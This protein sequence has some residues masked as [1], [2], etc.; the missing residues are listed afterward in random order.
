MEMMDSAEAPGTPLLAV[1]PCITAQCLVQRACEAVDHTLHAQAHL[2]LG[3][4]LQPLRDEGIA[5]ICSGMSFHNMQAFFGGPAARTSCKQ[6]AEV[7]L[8]S[9][10]CP[11][12]HDPLTIPSCVCVLAMMQFAKSAWKGAPAEDQ[13]WKQQ[14]VFP[15]TVLLCISLVIS[16]PRRRLLARR[17]AAQR[18]LHLCPLY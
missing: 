18:H 5:I 9:I 11:S 16:M 17:S 1:L 15:V 8:G 12:K 13:Q 2:H 7:G 6:A 3:E 14:Y 4:A 10:P